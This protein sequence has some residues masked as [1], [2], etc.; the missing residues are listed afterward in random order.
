M[1]QATFA[2]HSSD[3]IDAVHHL[4]RKKG[5]LEE[6]IQ[7]AEQQIQKRIIELQRRFQSVAQDSSRLRDQM[8]QLEAYA[9]AIIP[10]DW[11][12]QKRD[13]VL[14]QMHAIPKNGQP[15][16]DIKAELSLAGI[17]RLEK[18]EQ[19]LADA[20]RKL[21][22]WQSSL[23][24]ELQAPHTAK[25]KAAK[26]AQAVKV[27]AEKSAAAAAATMARNR[28]IEYQEKLSRELASALPTVSI[29]EFL[30]DLAKKY[31][32]PPKE[33]K[34]FGKLDDLLAKM[35]GLQDTAGW[36]DLMERAAAIRAEGDS[37][38]RIQFFESLCLEAG[39]RLKA[40][41]AVAAW[42]IEMDTMLEEASDYAGTA[43]D[44]IA[45]ELRELRLAGRVVSLESWQQRLDNA[46]EREGARLQR[47][48]QRR[49]ILESLTSLGYE[50][51][52]GM[53]TALV[54]GG[55]LVLRKPGESD[56]A[57]EMVA[58]ADL[59][60]MQT[61]MVRYS[62]SD[63][64]TEQQRLRDREREAEWC[65]DHRRIREQLDRRGYET[66]FKLQMPAGAHPVRVVK[67][68]AAPAARKAAR[69]QAQGH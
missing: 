49:A 32:L 6:L 58:N 50:T 41:R 46:K 23:E 48:H 66:S 12:E 2:V 8:A 11:P 5:S 3:G 42:Q 13:V 25:A 53:E 40:V 61:A 30:A 55:K 59:S 1:V 10:A 54:Q 38:R 35:G 68:D 20:N 34:A 43:V 14:K 22:Q 29:S 67:R 9:Q 63:T 15:T 56:Y 19:A 39:N 27:A 44:A 52:E 64:I 45:D 37:R 21:G 36:S 4:Y 62:D 17:A 69:R 7:R 31:V 28:E 65:D 18:A 33:C 16:L 26:V 51:S 24:T 47:E 60:M 57:I